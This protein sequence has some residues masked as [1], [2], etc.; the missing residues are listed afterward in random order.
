MKIGNFSIPKHEFN[1]RFAFG[2]ENK[3]MD[4]NTSSTDV[5]NRGFRAKTL[6]VSFIIKFNDGKALNDIVRLFEAVDDKGEQIVYDIIDETARATGIRKAIFDGEFLCPANDQGQFWTVSF[7]LK[8]QNSTSEKVEYKIRQ[9]TNVDPQIPAALTSTLSPEV[10]KTGLSAIKDEIFN[11]V[12]AIKEDNLTPANLIAKISQA[13]NSAKLIINKID[14]TYNLSS[15]PKI[16]GLDAKSSITKILSDIGGA[17]ISAL[18]SKVR[19][20]ESTRTLIEAN[21]RINSIKETIGG[22]KF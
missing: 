13:E 2:V 11:Q 19:A 6:K 12:N 5:S 15:L 4:G 7:Y 21:K 18:E 22:L 14:S 8:E 20:D 1:V 10:Q 17:K 3:A 16:G 9:G